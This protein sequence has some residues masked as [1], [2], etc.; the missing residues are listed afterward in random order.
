VP[1]IVALK[2]KSLFLVSFTLL[3]GKGSRDGV[4]INSAIVQRRPTYASAIASTSTKS[5]SLTTL[6]ALGALDLRV[7]IGALLRRLAT[8]KVVK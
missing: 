1:L 2:A 5:K 6:K 3:R 7:F 4:K 8:S